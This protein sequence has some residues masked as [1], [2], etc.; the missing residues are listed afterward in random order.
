MSVANYSIDLRS[1]SPN[2]TALNTSYSRFDTHHMT[3]G[4]KHENIVQMNSHRDKHNEG[5]LN[6]SSNQGNG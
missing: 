6:R 2:R 3:E 1:R 5:F 4:N